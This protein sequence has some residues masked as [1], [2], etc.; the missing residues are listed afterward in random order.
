MSEIMGFTYS[1]YKFQ[2]K[3]KSAAP[4][5]AHTK[6]ECNRASRCGVTDGEGVSDTL[7]TARAT[8]RGRHRR[9]SVPVK[10]MIDWMATS[11]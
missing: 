5:K 6:F 8:C 4:Y 11:Y 3:L 10:Y 1:R 9:V 7:S 2:K